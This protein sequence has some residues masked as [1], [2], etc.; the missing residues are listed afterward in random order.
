MVRLRPFMN[1]GLSHTTRQPL[2]LTGVINGDNEDLEW[3]MEEENS[4]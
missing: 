4:E 2:R 1:G 3:R